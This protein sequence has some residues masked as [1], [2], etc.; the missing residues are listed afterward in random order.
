LHS[1]RNSARNSVHS[2]SQ[3]DTSACA[4]ARAGLDAQH[5]ARG[6][7]ER[8]DQH[9]VLELDR[10]AE[11]ERDV[12]TPRSRST[13]VSTRDPSQ[14]ERGGDAGTHSSASAVGTLDLTRRDRP[15]AL[16][17]VRAVAL[18]V[19]HVVDEVDR[20]RT[21]AEGREGVQRAHHVAEV[22]RVLDRHVRPRERHRGE[23]EDVLDPLLGSH[24]ADDRG[25][26]HR[27]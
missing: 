4:A 19:E 5:E 9:D 11:V 7:A 13:A 6:D 8:V 3:C 22:G 14:R 27:G 10:V 12:E 15:V 16:G 17:R 23:H 24:R 20:A 21:Q 25:E 18:D 2:I 26:A 1:A